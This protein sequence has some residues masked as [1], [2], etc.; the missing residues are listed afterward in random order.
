M[1]VFWFMMQIAMI[2]GWATAYPANT[3]LLRKGW[4]ERMPMYPNQQVRD[5]HRLPPKAA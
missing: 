2:V 5:M 3:W 4:K 1:A